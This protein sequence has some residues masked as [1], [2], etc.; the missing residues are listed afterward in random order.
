MK[1][2]WKWVVL[3]AVAVM[4][5]TLVGVN[6]VRAETDPPGPEQIQNLYMLA[7]G[8]AGI[9]VPEKAPKVYRMS[10]AA[11]CAII[12]QGPKCGMK[13][14]QMADAVLYSEEL[15]FTNP[16]DSSVL[17]HELVHYVQYERPVLD[18][19]TFKW[20]KA[21]NAKPGLE[22]DK[23]EC[24][25]YKVQREVLAKVNVNFMVPEKYCHE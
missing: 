24:D 12:A 9:G 19:K 14:A 15:D 25:A 13:G 7:V 1:M 18:L 20:V 11:L 3:T 5:G 21:G 4:F 22:W 10:E 2:S 23:R 8:H 16:L 6:T 17:L